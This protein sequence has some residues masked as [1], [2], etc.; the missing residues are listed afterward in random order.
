MPAISSEIWLL[1][2][3]AG[4]AGIIGVLYA[5]AATIRDEH[6]LRDTTAKAARLRVQWSKGRRTEHDP[7]ADVDIV[8]DRPSKKAA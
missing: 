3:F 8:P 4:A 2:A 7:D 5:V 1:I 6:E